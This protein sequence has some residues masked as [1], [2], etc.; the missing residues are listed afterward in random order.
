MSS[1]KKIKELIK[2]LSPRP[3]L[4]ALRFIYTKSNIFLAYRYDERRY[5]KHSALIKRKGK[6]NLEAAITEKYHNIEK[7]LSLS[8][9]RP[10]FGHAQIFSLVKLTEEYVRDYGNEFISNHAILVLNSY[11]EFNRSHNIPDEKI[12]HFNEIRHLTQSITIVT[13]GDSGTRKILKKELDLIIGCT[14]K[15]FFFCRHSTRQFS[16]TPPSVEDIEYAAKVAAKSPAVC[17]RQFTKVRVYLEKNK[18]AELL[19]IQG[20]ARGFSDEITALAM[21]TVN[22]EAYWGVA[23]RNQ[24]W[25]DGGIF[26]MSFMLGLHARGLGSVALNWSKSPQQDRIMR[27][28]TQIQDSELIIMFVGFGNLKEEYEVAVSPRIPAELV[29]E[30]NG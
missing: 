26:A 22:T 28:A 12:P 11:I 30:V 4:P 8:K 23:E 16:K 6:K 19:S 2:K 10:C 29:L 15:E 3:L 17:N 27:K 21:I 20:G 18:I 9:P 24:G 13:P 14:N 25:I 7:G 5:T 1:Q